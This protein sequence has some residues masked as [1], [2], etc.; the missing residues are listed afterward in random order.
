MRST[1]RLPLHSPS[2][3]SVCARAPRSVTRARPA[4]WW[5][6]P[7]AAP[8]TPRASPSRAGDRGQTV[9]HHRDDHDT[10]RSGGRAAHTRSATRP[11]SA[12]W[13]PYD[14]GAG[15]PQGQSAG[16]QIRRRTLRQASCRP[17]EMRQTC[18]ALSHPDLV[19][20][21]AITDEQ[22]GPLL[23]EGGKGSFGAVRVDH[24]KA[25][26]SLAIT[27]N[28]CSVLVRNHEVSSI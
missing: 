26:L 23:N 15:V 16:G 21:I 20:P 3:A 5:V 11:P 19:H 24:M 1:Q 12:G 10:G 13:W 4:Y 22:P 2:H 6:P 8:K 9:R 25:T 17:D 18:L 14:R 28:Q 27:H 7:H